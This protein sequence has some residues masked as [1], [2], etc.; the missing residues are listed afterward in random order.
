MIGIA[1][2][3]AGPPRATVAPVISRAPVVGPW[4][5]TAN[6]EPVKKPSARLKRGC[7][8]SSS[9]YSLSLMSAPDAG[10][11]GSADG[12]SLIGPSAAPSFELLGMLEPEVRIKQ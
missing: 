10:V 6:S 12:V 4:N 3:K 2:M 8:P 7:T 11:A 5:A 9:R 1:Q